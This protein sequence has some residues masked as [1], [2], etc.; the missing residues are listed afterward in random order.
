MKR[1]TSQSKIKARDLGEQYI[2]GRYA[3]AGVIAYY[4]SNCGSEFGRK[5]YELRML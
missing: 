3:M 5:Y 1:Y 4:K 2:N